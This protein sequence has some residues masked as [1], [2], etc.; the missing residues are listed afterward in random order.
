MNTTFDTLSATAALVSSLGVHAA[1]AAP[2]Q[3]DHGGALLALRAAQV[4]LFSAHDAAALTALREA[5][6]AL[7]SE[8]PPQAIALASIDEAAVHIRRHEMHE[9]QAAIGQARQRL[10]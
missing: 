3:H 10:A 2:V 9:A 8:T 7:I 1:D 4:E 5:R 6:R